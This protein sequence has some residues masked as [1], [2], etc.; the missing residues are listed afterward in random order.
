MS[1]TRSRDWV[2]ADVGHDVLSHFLS[3]EARAVSSSFDH[4]YR[5]WR[6]QLGPFAEHEVRVERRHQLSNIVTLMVDSHPFVEACAEDI[7]CEGGIWECRFRFIGERAIDFQIH[8]TTRFGQPLDKKSCVT[9]RRKYEHK[10]HVKI[11]NLSDFSSA[12]FVLDDVCFEE[13][14]VREVPWREANISMAL[15][16]MTM[17]YGLTPPYKIAEEEVAAYP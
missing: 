5:S 8:E 10:F 7:D 12:A 11:D 14:H 6:I 1:V 16:A 9:Q 3:D 2:S 15:D 4:S 13:L 17:Q